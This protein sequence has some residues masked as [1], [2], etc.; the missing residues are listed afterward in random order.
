M[1]YAFSFAGIAFLGVIM[2]A[3]IDRYRFFRASSRTQGEGQSERAPQV[4]EQPRTPPAD[5]QEM[6]AL[7]VMHG[8]RVFGTAVGPLD[9]LLVVK[10]RVRLVCEHWSWT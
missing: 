4:T 7:R 9:D 3:V 10:E 6:S 1:A 2:K 8:E 5:P